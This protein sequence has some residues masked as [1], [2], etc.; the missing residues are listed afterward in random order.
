MTTLELRGRIT[1]NGNLEVHLPSGLPAGEVIV[2][3]DVRHDLPQKEQP[4]SDEEISEMLNPKRSSFKELV[5]WLETNPP[6]E[7]WGELDDSQDAAEYIHK[8]RQTSG[9]PQ[10]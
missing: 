8:L 9:T 10:K 5:E 4:W 6:T 3:I 7:P 2:R 1:E